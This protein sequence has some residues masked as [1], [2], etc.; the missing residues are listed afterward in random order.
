MPKVD[1]YIPA[2][3]AGEFS[4]RMVART[5][6]NKYPLG[7]A[8]AENVLFLPQGGLAR[9]PGTRYIGEV[10]DSSV[11][12]RHLPFVFST[13]PANSQAYIIEAGN[14]YFRFYRNKAQIVVADTDAAISNGTFTSN[15]T[16]WDDRSSGGT[17]AIAHGTAGPVTEGTLA[18]P[19]V[20]VIG[21]GDSA[22]EGLSLGMK[23]LNSTAGTIAS[24]KIEVTTVNAAFN[25]VA[26]LYSDNS[27][28]PGTQ[29]GSDSDTVAL[30]STGV[31]EFSFSTQPSVSAATSYWIVIT[32]TTADGTGDVN[33]SLCAD[34]GSNFASGRDDTITDIA[35]ASGSVGAAYDWR[36]DILVET[37]STEGVLSLVGD[38]GEIASAEQDVTTTDTDQEHVLTFKVNGAPGDTIVL[39]IG[40]VS[41]GGGILNDLELGVGWHAIAFTP[42]VS[43]FYVQFQN[44]QAKT[45][46]IDDVALI[47]DA[48]VELVTPYTTAELAAL[49]VAQTADVMYIYHP[50]HATMKLERRG[51]TTW[52]LVEVAWE[53]GPWLD[54][55]DTATT[56]TPAATTGFGITV[57]ATSVTGING[58]QGFLSGDVGRLV[59]IKNGTDWGYAVIVS[60]DGPT[61]VTVDVQSDFADTTANAAWRLGAWSGTTGYPAGGAF[62]EQ[63]LLAWSTRGSIDAKPQSFWLSQSADLENMRPDSLE[64]SAIEVQDDDAL[65]FTIA[66]DQVNVILW[67]SSGSQLVL[68]T[69]GGEWVV[70]SDGP[71]LTP[72]DIDVK[73]STTYGSTDIVPVRVS[74][75]VLFLDRSGRRLREFAFNFDTNDF[76]SPDMTILADHILVGGVTEMAYQQSP[77]SLLWCVRGDG[78][79]VVLTYLREQNVVGWAR[80]IVGGSFSSG[81]AVVESVATIPGNTTNSTED[82]DEVWIIVKRT[83]N[84]NTVRYVETVEPLFEG[85]FPDHYDSESDLDTAVLAVQDLAHYVDSAITYDST[86]TTS[87]TGLD[88]LEGETVKVLADGAVRP[89]ATVSSG[90]I[91]LATSASTVKVGLGY[92]HKYKSLKL[93]Y[94]NPAGSAVGKT[95]RIHGLTF[96]MLHSLRLK[97]GSDFSDLREKDFRE[98]A[99]EMDTAVPLFSGEDFV[100]FPGEYGEDP[101][102]VLSDDVPAPFFVLAMAPEMK[103]NQPL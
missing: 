73:R 12:T 87:I 21:H 88:H 13:D 85:P 84:G 8:R 9:R 17:A 51:H 39:R 3:N 24:V 86:A 100:D 32:D 64:G 59:R 40:E 11:Q 66:A 45:V 29:I 19:Q 5:D 10:K 99:D 34:Q 89:D 50:D 82:E 41:E 98:V 65:D 36:M 96:V 60:V 46:S 18:N 26:A 97:Y 56:F 81:D 1:P 43:P 58:D 92:D 30:S 76:R 63:R 83:I 55:N 71:N 2:L 4:P 70:Q 62:F 80:Q 52:S 22:T 75:V 95:K 74:H 14:N 94:G 33:I 42:T 72:T 68:G 49:K 54:Q 102:I 77:D 44:S 47:D 6:F 23:F 28:N 31:K 57:T 78:Q 90:A 20:Q 61:E 79:L 67:M 103:T 101:R 53:D 25:A 35:D 38:S 27:G 16:G 69:S 91:T 48:A 93:A 7:A 15:I 37:S